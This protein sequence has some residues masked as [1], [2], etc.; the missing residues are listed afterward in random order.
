MDLSPDD[1]LQAYLIRQQL[2]AGIHPDDIIPMRRPG[3]GP[4]N[5]PAAPAVVRIT[6]EGVSVP[7]IP[8][9]Q[10]RGPLQPLP[11]QLRAGPGGH[12]GIHDVE[13]HNGIVNLQARMLDMM[14]GRQGARYG[15]LPPN[16]AQVV[17]RVRPDDAAQA[18]AMA[19]PAPRQAFDLIG[20]MT[21]YPHLAL[22]LTSYLSADDLV[23]LTT[24]SRPFFNFL[25]I[26]I[27]IVVRNLSLQIVETASIFPPLCYPRLNTEPGHFS[28]PLPPPINEY[29]YILHHL[30]PSI[31]YLRMITHRHTTT[32][33]IM[34][35]LR[36]AGYFIPNLCETPLKK[37]WFLMDIPDNARREWTIAN[38]HLWRDGEIFFATFF[39]VQLDMY[40]REQRQQRTNSFRQLIMAQPT[41]TFLREFLV[42]RVCAT[43]LDTLAEFVRWR[44]VP[45]PE[46]RNEQVFGVPIAETGLLQFEGYGRPRV[47]FNNYNIN[48]ILREIGRRGLD[49][50]IMFSEIFLLRNPRLFYVNREPINWD[51]MIMRGREDMGPYWM[52]LVRLD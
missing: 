50:H 23:N 13:A 31:P 16:P 44:Y 37:L 14:E 30:V 1:A 26:N 51:E 2:I 24:Q 4:E 5:R 38:P 8:P 22:A 6:N 35:L 34:A 21:T 33:Q 36:Q 47:T 41:L 52:D 40:L 18:I 32:T 25:N 15:A 12:E 11:G 10:F 9:A 42:G 45:A 29:R 28:H 17:A 19:G 46:E 49:M 3:H 48:L 7:E 27:G 20:A 39:I 43:N